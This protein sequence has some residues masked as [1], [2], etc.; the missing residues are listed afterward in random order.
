MVKQR[1]RPMA[2]ANVFARTVGRV[3]HAKTRSARLETGSC[4]VAMAS[5]TRMAAVSAAL[6]G[7]MV[8]RTASQ[9][10]QL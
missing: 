5:A 9:F 8:V 6:I 2:L 7:S 3:S 1:F 4:V 10:V